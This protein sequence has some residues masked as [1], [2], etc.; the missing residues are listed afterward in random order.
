MQAD[1]NLDQEIAWGLDWAELVLMVAEEL[2]SA[3]AAMVYPVIRSSASW[4]TA[5]VVGG[6]TQLG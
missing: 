5:A 6:D 2:I 1:S 4:S 3:M